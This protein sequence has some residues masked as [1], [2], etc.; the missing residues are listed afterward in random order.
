MKFE[1]ISKTTSLIL[2]IGLLV[3][4]STYAL[5]YFNSNLEEEISDTSHKL[6]D[7]DLYRLCYVESGYVDHDNVYTSGFFLGF[8]PGFGIGRVS[9]GLIGWRGEPRL[10]VKNMFGTTIYDYDV[11]VYL[12]GFIGCIYPT[13]SIYQGILKGRAIIAKVSPLEY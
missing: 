3:V 6:N 7:E 2:L 1:T 8:P 10:K 12:R 5:E 4:P 9:V 11:H 13:V